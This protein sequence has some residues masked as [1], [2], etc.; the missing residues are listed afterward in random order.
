MTPKQRIVFDLIERAANAGLPAPSNLELANAIGSV[1]V[2]S[3]AYLVSVLER[4]RLIHVERFGASRRITIIGTSKST[5]APDGAV[6]HWRTRVAADGTYQRTT[7][8][9]VERKDLPAAPPR[10]I[11][12]LV[13]VQRDPCPNC[14]VRGDIGCKHQP[15]PA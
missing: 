11:V 1:G 7:P 3:G 5:L 13:P 12:A 6:A 2:A 8:R 15:V 14:G 9:H 4:E 10:A